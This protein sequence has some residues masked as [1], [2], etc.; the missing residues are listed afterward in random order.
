MYTYIYVS[1]YTHIHTHITIIISIKV[2][3]III[4]IIVTVV[5]MTACHQPAALGLCVHK[6]LYY[7]Y[8]FLHGLLSNSNY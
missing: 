2:I 4:I 3:I 6:L 7:V 1:I 8:I 5:I